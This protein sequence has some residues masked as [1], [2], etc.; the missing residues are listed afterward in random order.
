M[1]QDECLILNYNDEVIGA[2]N[3]Y[4]AH[5]FVSGQPKGI[6]HRAFS[7]MLFDSHGRLLLQQRAMDKVTFPGVW[8]NTACSHPLYGQ[9]PDEVD[10][11]RD[12]TTK[13]PVGVQRAAIRKLHH[14]LGIEPKTLEKASFKY[15]GRV[16]YWAADTL[17]HG[18][19]S[20]WGEHEI[21]YL[22]LVRL[23]KRPAMAGED[24]PMA[25]NPEE[26]MAIDWVTAAELEAKMSDASLRWSPWF[27]VIADRFLYTWWKDLDKAWKLKAE[28]KIY[29]FDAVAQ[30]RKEDGSH[31]GPAATELGELMAREAELP[32]NSKARRELTLRVEREQRRRDLTSRS[33]A[34]AKNVKQGA[35]GKVQTHSVS[36]WAQLAHPMEVASALYLKL[37]P[38]ALPSNLAVSD[39]DLRFCDEKL[40]QVSRSFAA[41][42]RQLP[43]EMAVD[44]LVFYLILRGL[45]TIED[46]MSAFAGKEAEKCAHLR[47]FGPKY[48][49]DVSWRLTGVGEGEEAELLAGFGAVSKVFNAL[50]AASQ[51]VIRD[52]TTRMGA[53][54][55]DYV[56]VDMGQ[57]TVDLPAYCLYCHSLAGLVGEGLSRAFIARGFESRAI[58]GQG[59]QVWPFCKPAGRCDGM[60]Y[61]LANSMGLFLQK[62]NIIRDY[63]E[64]YVD[65]RA[66]W[67]QD[68]WRTYAKT[69]D[70]GEFARPTTHGAGTYASAFDAAV[71]PLGAAI[72]GKA[73]SCAA[74]HCLNHMI[75]DAL[76][77]V[78]DCLEYL[79]RL[80]TPEV[81]RFSAIP[82]VMA[83]A[84]IE[85]CFDNPRVFT[86]VVKIRKG[87]AA[88][89]ILD[90]NSMEGVHYWFHH[91][92]TQLEARCPETDPSRGKILAATTRIRT[93]CEPAATARSRRRVALV[94]A[95]LVFLVAVI[96]LRF[97]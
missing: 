49:G 82:Q 27:R 40:G 74:L 18:S 96:A 20:P 13:E 63:L 16:H 9:T 42:I 14:E 29:R 91:F 2:E 64:D 67:P 66:F 32:W 90:S 83:I 88:R 15:M 55:A 33:A 76:E 68:V 37:M 38:G 93:L 47:N 6:V 92:A 52:I 80:R 79:G 46:D 10:P 45:D 25:V 35:Y 94:W 5:K 59:E 60:T 50:P 1:R 12:G 19:H 3:K 44:I 7:V 56:G 36:K 85:A 24:L 97:Y 53:G 71:D 87:L 58:G 73:A 8:T 21:D 34:S 17:T 78:P 43:R 61:G 57:G 62:T 28:E 65:G 75:A 4:N 77:L 72:V 22:V 31:D 11:P 81:F 51:E 23:P 30:H 41:V 84:T 48:L 54:M 86:G 69:T 70:L 39:A 89:L 26:V 95:F